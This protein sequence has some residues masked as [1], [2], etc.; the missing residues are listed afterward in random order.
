MPRV[1]D[2]DVHGGV[3]REGKLTLH[4]AGSHRL[5]DGSA[6]DELRPLLAERPVV[7]DEVRNSD[8]KA[9]D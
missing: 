7:D 8:Q 4:S 2:R 5:L 9:E 3:E 6:A 1:V